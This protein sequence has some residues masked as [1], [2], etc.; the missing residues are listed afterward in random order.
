MKLENLNLNANLIYRLQVFCRVVLA[1]IVGFAIANL[2]AAAI[3]LIFSSQQAVATYSGMLLSFVLWL[4]FI[5]AI[6]TIKKTR[7]TVWLS[8]LLLVGL[9]TVVYLL[10]LWGN[11]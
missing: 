8:G 11:A 9:S 7:H 6:F 10:K 5:I 1:S 3:G 2:A 4:I